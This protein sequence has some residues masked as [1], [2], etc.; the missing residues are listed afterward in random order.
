MKT[1]PIIQSLLDTDLYKFTMMQVV[2]HQFPGAEVEYHFR[3]R[4]KGINLVPFMKEIEEEIE[5]Y[6]QLRFTDKELG[7]LSKMRFLKKDF[8]EFLELYRP[9]MKHVKVVRSETE[10]GAIDIIVQGPWL[11]TIPFEVPILSIVSEV[12][13][14]N[15]V[16]VEEAMVKGKKI[17]IEKITQAQAHPYFDKFRFNDFGT[18]RRFSRKWH[19]QVVDIMKGVMPIQFV[20][21]SNIAL[22][23]RYGLTVMGTM[24]HEYL[25]ACQALGPRLRDSQVFAFDKW[26]DEYQGDL[27]IALTDVIGMD[28]FLDDFNLKF[29]KLYDGMRHDSGDPY[30]WAEK[31]IA[32]YK[33]NRID[34]TSKS[35]VFS[36]GLNFQKA[37]DLGQYFEGRA[38]T[39]F[40]IGTDITN[41]MGFPALNNVM[42][43]THCNGQPVAKRSDTPGKSMCTDPNYE[44]ALAR[45]FN[46]QD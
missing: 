24:A 45:A 18:R 41:D 11:F 4:N 6:C 5:A 38:T 42:K 17:L 43:M 46:I 34:P 2:Y 27:G 32:H 28:Q 29:C 10:S 7:V 19:E 25:Q 39:R 31:A 30:K 12:Y 16:D 44:K 26:V 40:G 9:R 1:T 8:I 36:D 37:M 23:D 35:L 21:S 3:C 33:T 15:T 13:F 20:G 22:A 14:R